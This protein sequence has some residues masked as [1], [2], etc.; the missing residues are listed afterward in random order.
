MPVCFLAFVPSVMIIDGH[1]RGRW[2]YE[3]TEWTFADKSLPASFDGYRVVHISDLHLEGF[4]DNPSYLDTLVIRV[5]ELQPDI[6]FFTGDLVSYNSAGLLPF[7]RTLRCLKAK[8]GVVSILGNHDYAIYDKSLD[9]L[10]R[11][12][13]RA[14]LV[15]L[16]RQELRWRLLLNENFILRHGSDSV[17]VIGCENQ[18]CGFR[19]K[20][21]RGDLAKA[22]R[23]TQHMYQILLTHDPSHWD[24]E[25]KGKT[26]IRLTLSGHTHAM[27]CKVFDWTPGRIFF[28]RSDGAYKDGFQQLYVNIGLGQLIPFRIGAKPEITLITFK[29]C[30]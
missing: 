26:N 23:G 16:Q 11:E 9:S 10:Q 27:Q 4:A 14:E 15:R 18:A 2:Q 7:V 25:V 30:E 8:D 29:R 3:V 22:L 20:V 17:A 13:D 24:A 28:H 19:R 6:I 21:T 5:N 1:Y 12:E